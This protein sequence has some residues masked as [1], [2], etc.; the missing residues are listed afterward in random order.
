MKSRSVEGVFQHPQAITLTENQADFR[1]GSKR[2][3]GMLQH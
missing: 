3:I 1:S 2:A